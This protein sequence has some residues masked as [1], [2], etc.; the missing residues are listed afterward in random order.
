MKS[1]KRYN[2]NNDNNNNNNNNNIPLTVKPRSNAPAFNIIPPIQHINFGPKKYV[3]SYLHIGNGENLNL[4][5]RFGQS[6]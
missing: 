3:Y 6:L 2:N 1:N 4:E 5:Y